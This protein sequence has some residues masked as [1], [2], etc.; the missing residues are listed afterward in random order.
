MLKEKLR[1]FT[2]AIK[3]DGQPIVFSAL[4][5]WL[6]TL[7][8]FSIISPITFVKV[9][10]YTDSI[11]IIPFILTFLGLFTALYLINKLW[12]KKSLFLILQVDI[13]T[14]RI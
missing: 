9:P 1:V 7:S 13:R 2:N 5:A 12:L 4:S 11:A 8:I 10:D 3:K 14:K 6:L